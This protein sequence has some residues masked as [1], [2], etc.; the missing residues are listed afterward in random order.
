MAKPAGMTGNGELQELR[1]FVWI[2]Y[3]TDPRFHRT[4]AQG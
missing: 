4:I 3:H 2:A 1:P